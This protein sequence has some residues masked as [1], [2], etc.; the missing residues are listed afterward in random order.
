MKFD[1]ELN[2]LMSLSL[3]SFLPHLQFMLCS[4]V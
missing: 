1:S 4:L 3:L 2:F